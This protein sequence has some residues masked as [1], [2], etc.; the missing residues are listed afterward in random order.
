MKKKFILK[1]A[2]AAFSIYVVAM[3]V[4]IQIDVTERKKEKEMMLDKLN[5]QQIVNQNL[6][7]LLKSG[8][9]EEYIEQYAR[10]WLGYAMPDERIFINRSGKN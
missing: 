7:R 9:D 3:F 1:I 2:I 8:N 4:Q 5:Q 6:S 10:Q